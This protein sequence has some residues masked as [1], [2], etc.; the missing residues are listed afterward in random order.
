VEKECEKE[1]KK[2]RKKEN[3]KKTEFWG[4]KCLLRDYS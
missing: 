1:R 4:R 2:E 3:T